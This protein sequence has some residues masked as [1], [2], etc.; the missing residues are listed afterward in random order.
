MVIFLP[1]A[2]LGCFN[3]SSTRIFTS[4]SFVRPRKGPPDA[5][6]RIFSILS[7][8]SPFSDWKIA[9]CSLST[10]RMDTPHFFAKGMM[11]WPAVTRVSLFASA[12]SLPLSMAA[13]VGLMP[14]MPTIAVTRT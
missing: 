12:M 4:C 10:G 11:I 14:I 9:E 2:Q 7:F 13:M 8:G 5:V 1:I 3:A 6:S